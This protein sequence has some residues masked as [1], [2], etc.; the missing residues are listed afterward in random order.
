MAAI[1]GRGDGVAKRRMVMPTVLGLLFT[2]LVATLLSRE[3]P[4]GVETFVVPSSFQGS[5]AASRNP[6]MVGSSVGAMLTTPEVESGVTRYLR[7]F[8]HKGPKKFPGYTFV[9][10]TIPEDLVEEAAKEGFRLRPKY[11]HMK[12]GYV[13][14]DRQKKTRIAHVEYFLFN[15][16][17][18]AYYKQSKRFHF[19]DE[20]EISKLGD[21][22]L[23]APF[24]K[25]TTMKHY[26][27]IEVLKNNTAPV[28]V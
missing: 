16:K 14:S 1:T 3:S 18:G 6:L 4:S 19:H 17:L 15:A 28:R 24:R 5:A 26:R 12:V 22:V 27:I 11:H 13:V 10:P 7:Q 25:K 8:Q 2:G 20:Y 23:I 9:E 21:V